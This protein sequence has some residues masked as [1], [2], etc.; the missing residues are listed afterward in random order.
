MGIPNKSPQVISN[1][2]FFGWFETGSKSLTASL[3]TW[4]PIIV[5]SLSNVLSRVTSA[6][7][8]DRLRSDSAFVCPRVRADL[9]TAGNNLYLNCLSLDCNWKTAF[10]YF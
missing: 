6:A 3:T 4:S 9:I 10:Q 1:S 2:N 7:F 8:T 5:F